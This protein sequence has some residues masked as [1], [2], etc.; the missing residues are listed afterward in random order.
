MLLLQFTLE[1]S[2]YA[3]SKQTNLYLHFHIRNA[4]VGD[5]LAS[6]R[7]IY[8]PFCS[9]PFQESSEGL[10]SDTPFMRP[11]SSLSI[12]QSNCGAVD[13]PLSC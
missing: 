10:P 1:Y 13:V 6:H 7:T 12:A 11:H 5:C 2:L 8:L 4:T 9:R 3:V